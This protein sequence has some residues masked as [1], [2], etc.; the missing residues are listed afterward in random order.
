MT[1]ELRKS[2][3][4]GESLL[5]R[6]NRVDP[7]WGPQLVVLAAILLD[8]SLARKISPIKPTWVL[9]A[10]EALALVALTIAS[11]HPCGQTRRNS[12]WPGREPGS[13]GRP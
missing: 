6:L 3:I 1:D 5:D 4:A 2:E 12:T 13:R 8:L 10:L 11:P 9:P 7:Y